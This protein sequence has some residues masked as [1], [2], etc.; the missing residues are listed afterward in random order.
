MGTVTGREQYCQMFE[1]GDRVEDNI[2]TFNC[3]D[4]YFYIDTIKRFINILQ[5]RFVCTYVYMH[6]GRC[7]R[8]ISWPILC[9]NMHRIYGYRGSSW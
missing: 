4:M 7:R 2:W 8:V 5:Y 3:S 1:K 6:W 9:L